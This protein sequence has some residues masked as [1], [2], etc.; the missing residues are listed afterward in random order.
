[1]GVRWGWFYLL[2]CRIYVCCCCLAAGGSWGC[3]WLIVCRMVGEEIFKGRRRTNN[4]LA[5]GAGFFWCGRCASATEVQLRLWRTDLAAPVDTPPS[6][7]QAF[8]TC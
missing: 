2:Q 6:Q 7:R 8:F 5:I 3:S 4:R 1:M